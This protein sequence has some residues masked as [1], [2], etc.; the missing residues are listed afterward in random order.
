MSTDEIYTTGFHVKS[1]EIVTDFLEEL[2]YNDQFH[3]E[4]ERTVFVTKTREVPVILYNT[5]LSIDKPV[6]AG[7]HYMEMET[8]ALFIAVGTELVSVKLLNE[9]E[10]FAYSSPVKL[11]LV[12]SPFDEAG[13][14]LHLGEE[15][16]HLRVRP[17]SP[18][19]CFPGPIPTEED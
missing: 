12:S 18:L 13:Q 4:G 1:Y 7:N 10:L 17:M 19:D 8:E 5:V 15:D 9:V 11:V 16:M 6:K 2:T 3:P 14:G